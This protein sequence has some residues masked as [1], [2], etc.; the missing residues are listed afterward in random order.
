MNH[1]LKILY[2][3]LFSTTALAQIG[4]HKEIQTSQQFGD[5]TLH[6]NVFNSK[7]IPSEVAK[8]YN[9]NRAKDIV[10]LNISLTKTEN[11]AASL[12]MPAVIKLKATNLMQQSKNIELV[13]IKEAEATYYLAPFRINNEELWRFE[14]AVQVTP[15]QKPFTVKFERTLYKE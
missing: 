4:Q 11:G 15:E 14:A 5:Y 10:Y 9:L 7:K 2:L 8:I 12:G 1:F 13:E 3:L 6:Y